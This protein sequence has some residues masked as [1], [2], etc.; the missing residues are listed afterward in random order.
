MRSA[1]SSLRKDNDSMTPFEQVSSRVIKVHIHRWLI[2][3]CSGDQLQL[4]R[5]VKDVLWEGRE[6]HLLILWPKLIWKKDCKE[7]TLTLSL[8]PMRFLTSRW[9][10]QHFPSFN[11]FVFLSSLL[12]LQF[13]Y[14]PIPREWKFNKQKILACPPKFNQSGFSVLR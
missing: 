9:T 3:P 13:L 11:W 5:F 10:V 7:F 6:Y 14:L 4:C 12:S 1:L 8:I 2:L